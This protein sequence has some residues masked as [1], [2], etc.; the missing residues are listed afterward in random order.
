M[1]LGDTQTLTQH[2]D[3]NWF[4]VTVSPVIISVG[5][6]VT[7][8]PDIISVGPNVTVLHLPPAQIKS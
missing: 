2:P 3:T 7:V 5:P 8:S 1:V 4:Y 6:Y